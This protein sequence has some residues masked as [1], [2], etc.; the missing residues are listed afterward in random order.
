[1]RILGNKVFS[2]VVLQLVMKMVTILFLYF[3]MRRLAGVIPAVVSSV[4]F[5][6]A[7]SNRS[8]LF[9]ADAQCLVFF[10]FAVAVYFTAGLFELYR[11]DVGSARLVFRIIL[12]ALFS[13]VCCVLEP[14]C[15]M[16]LLFGIALGLQDSEWYNGKTKACLF[17]SYIIATIAVG[18]VFF[19]ITAVARDVDLAMVISDWF[20]VLKDA[21]A[22]H[23]ALYF[24]E[25]VFRTTLEGVV[26]ACL[27]FLN[28]P[29]YHVWDSAKQI[30]F[31]ILLALAP[32]PFCTMGT[33][34]YDLFSLWIWA[35]LAGIGLQL[36]LS[37]KVVAEQETPVEEP[38]KEIPVAE[39]APISDEEI[40]EVEE[41]VSFE[42]EH[43]V[44]EEV[45]LEEK[46]D[47]HENVS[48]E[49]DSNPEANSL[50]ETTSKPVQYLHNPLPVPK[51]HVKRVADYK[52]NV[53]EDDDFDFDIH[54]DDDFDF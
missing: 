44:E 45:S 46:A 20:A 30:P 11:K 39:E 42:E 32:V 35:A 51:K 16:S 13:G 25:D 10:L 4:V 34:E 29:G 53:V 52:V 40:T 31:L 47:V 19:T 6:F 5:A 33:L 43:V 15:M 2:A 23:Y 54:E 18:F 22:I 24:Q 8:L 1:M 14:Y 28:L 26:L 50:L 3:G 7:Y 49:N 41:S 27:V 17:L 37:P 9:E 36:M 12:A 48:V 38:E 21:K